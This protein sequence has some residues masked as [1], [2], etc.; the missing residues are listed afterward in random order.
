MCALV[1]EACTGARTLGVAGRGGGSG[2][3]D[4]GVSLWG[5][6]REHL[7]HRHGRCM[8]KARGL[9]LHNSVLC[10]GSCE[11]AGGEMEER[12]AAVIIVLPPGETW[13]EEVAR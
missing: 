7:E 10:W 3:Q 4:T 2:I 5:M 1:P 8:G 11:S 13:D 6:G 12:V 9:F